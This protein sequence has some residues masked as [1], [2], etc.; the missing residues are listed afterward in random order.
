[1]KKQKPTTATH[2]ATLP[3]F[4]AFVLDDNTID[5]TPDGYGLALRFN[6][7]EKGE[8][9]FRARLVLDAEIHPFFLVRVGGKWYL[10]FE[11]VAPDGCAAPT[12][13]AVCGEESGLSFEEAAR[14]LCGV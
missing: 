3:A 1:M 12:F 10:N 8:S 11:I 7:E 13:A 4:T 14:H 6:G 5:E 9:V 2:A